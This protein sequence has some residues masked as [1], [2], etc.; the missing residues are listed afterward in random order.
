MERAA[1]R[2][3]LGSTNPRL[4]RAP[5]R[6]SKTPATWKCA[7]IFFLHHLN[8]DIDAGREAYFRKRFHNRGVDIYDVDE[9]LMHP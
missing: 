9:A 5:P 8:L 2:K 4:R 6:P 1:G 7:G 3:T